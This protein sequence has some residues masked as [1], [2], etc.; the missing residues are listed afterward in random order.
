MRQP[1]GPRIDA[2]DT[3]FSS[4]PFIV[5]NLLYAA[6]IVGVT[7]NLVTHD[8]VQW[9]IF[10]MD[11]DTLLATGLVSDPG[12]DYTY[13][14]VAANAAGDFMLA[15]NRSG[16][17]NTPADNISAYADHCQFDSATRSVSC[18][19]PTLLSQGL[20]GDYTQNGGGRFRWGDYSA[21]AIDPSNSSVFWAAVEVPISSGIWGT[22]I[23]EIVVTPEPAAFVFTGIGMALLIACRRRR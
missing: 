8:A 4:S 15:F 6:N 22:Q 16:G 10:N 17:A 19:S 23:T 2:N 7:D 14:S 12:F 9:L 18:E 11:T 21:I 1:S 13:V 5:G 20:T 3:R